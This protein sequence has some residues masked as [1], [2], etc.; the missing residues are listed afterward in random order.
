MAD[1]LGTQATVGRSQVYYLDVTAPRANK[2]DGVAAL[3]HA[4]GVPLPQV[5]VFGDQRNDLPMFVRAGLSV[6]M[7][8][9]PEE[10]RAAATHVSTSNDE[11]GV[12]VAIDRFILHRA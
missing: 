6:A 2:G 4:A 5:A 9:G 3:A 1:A 11:D 12:A 8:Q 10:V 7:A